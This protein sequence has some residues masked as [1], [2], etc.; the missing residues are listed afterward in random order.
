MTPSARIAAAI[1]VLTEIEARKRPA[2]DVLKDWGHA[3]RFAGAK[4]RAAISSLVFDAVRKRS[5]SAFIMREE[6]PRAIVLGTLRQAR[7]MNASDI[8]PLC[9]GAPHAPAPLNEQEMTR[10]SA[11]DLTGAPDYVAGDFPEWLEPSL[12]LAFG[13]ALVAEMRAFAIRAPVDLRANTLKTTRGKALEA[14]KHL[15]AVPTP[16]SPL[17][18]RLP[19][20]PDGLGQKLSA[21]PL[22]VR[23]LVEIQDEAS[24]LAALLS[25]A[26][27]GE[28]VLDICAGACGK[29]LALAAMMQNKGQIHAA[30]RD[31]ARLMKGF[32]RLKRAGVRNVQLHPPRN[33]ANVLGG[34]AGRSDL[35]FIDAPCTGTGTWRR[36]PDAK[37]RMRPGALAIRIAEQ[38]RLLAQAVWFVKPLGRILYAT[39]SILREENED[40]LMAFLAAHANYK[41]VAAPQLAGMAGLPELGRFASRLGLG[42]RLSPLTSNTDGFYIA[43]LTLA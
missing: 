35:V 11:A 43:M 9:S 37:W 13:P 30:D 18:L 32:A 10:L 6:T 3:N 7:N 33:G 14:L 38:D 8:F 27:P 36:N 15:D 28:Q 25:C 34:L 29:T 16:F 24:Q 40:R 22:Y 17:G 31:G 26:G 21:E 5:S 2:A 1:E 19:V 39:C 41:P 4:D 20:L 23:G 42:L 12:A